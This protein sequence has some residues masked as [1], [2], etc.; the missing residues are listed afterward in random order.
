MASAPEKDPR[1]GFML[2]AIELALENVRSGVG[3]PF[4]ALVVKDGAIVGRGANHVTSTNDPTAHAE[5]VAIRDACKNLGDFQLTGCDIYCTCEPC[6]MCWG[7]I[8]WAR[9]ARV[10]YAT[11]RLDAAAAEFADDFIARELQVPIGQRRIP[12]E[13]VMRDEALAI[14]QAWAGKED[15]RKY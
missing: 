1:R 15:R 10:I 11:T 13:Q 8:Y 9:M 14:F 4:A 6:P 7:A 3:G 2:R 5:V 12:A